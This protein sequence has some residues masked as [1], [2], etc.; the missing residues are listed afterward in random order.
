MRLWADFNNVFDDG[1]I[2]TVVNVFVRDDE[3]LIGQAVGMYDHEGNFCEGIIEH[4]DG[5]IVRVRLIEQTWIDAD[6]VMVEPAML[7]VR[8]VVESIMGG[9]VTLAATADS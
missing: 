7:P 2:C 3:P 4:A 1:T 6:R 5:S 9:N 8:A